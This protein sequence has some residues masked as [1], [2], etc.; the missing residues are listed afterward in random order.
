MAPRNQK[1]PKTPATLILVQYEGRRAG[2]RALSGCAAAAALA[3]ALDGAGPASSRA[4][5]FPVP[6][7]RERMQ[8]V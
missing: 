4:P 2:I 5:S 7:L 6:M 3:A 8:N 1:N